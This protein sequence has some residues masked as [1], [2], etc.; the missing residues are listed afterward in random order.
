MNQLQRHLFAKPPWKSACQDVAKIIEP[1][2]DDTQCGFCYGGSSTQHISTL[3]QIL[4]KSW[5]HSKDLYTC[6]VDLGKV[7]GRVPRE[8][9]WGLLWEFNADGCLLLAV[10]LL[11]SCSEDCGPADEL[12]HNRSALVLD[13]D[14]G[15]WS[16]LLF[17]VYTRVLHTTARGPN[18]TCEAISP[19]RKT[20]F[21]DNE[22]IIHL[23]KMCRFGRIKN[24]ITQDVWPSN[25]C[26]MAYVWSLPKSLKSL[27]LYEVDRQSQTHRQGRHCWEK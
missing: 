15:V 7:Y 1:K 4:E 20:H 26:A 8:K 27:G 23:R 13:F 6:F 11:Y 21:A 3:Q 18:P 17:K 14:N 22:K 12:T 19:V 2:L 24:N 5:K 9:L 10:K 25:Y 16:P